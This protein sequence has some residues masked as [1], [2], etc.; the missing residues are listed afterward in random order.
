LKQL[1]DSILL[2]K[3]SLAKYNEV[4]VFNTESKVSYLGLFDW[5]TS[6]LMVT[7]DAIEAVL[8]KDGSEIWYGWG[9]RFG[10]SPLSLR[11]SA[12]G[13]IRH[14]LN[15]NDVM[16]QKLTS[17]VNNFYQMVVPRLVASVG[18]IGDVGIWIFI[19]T[20]TDGLKV[21]AGTGFGV[22]HSGSFKSSFSL[23]EPSGVYTSEMSAILLTLMQITA[24]LPG[25]YLILTNSMSSLKDLQ[26]Q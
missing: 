25:R 15:V 12:W 19:D 6:S 7:C 22:Y 4:E 5:W 26:T 17:V 8:Y 11:L 23:R 3:S 24:R 10:T 2:I 18:G 16:E 13:V 9:L 1:E 14:V 20:F 21:G